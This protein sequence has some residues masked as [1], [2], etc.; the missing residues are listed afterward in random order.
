VTASWTVEQIEEALRERDGDLGIIGGVQH[1]ATRNK[2]GGVNPYTF[3]VGMPGA[4]STV[5]GVQL[6]S[7]DST[8]KPAAD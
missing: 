1:R 8:R 7:L 2:D 5:V 4:A 6:I 3:S